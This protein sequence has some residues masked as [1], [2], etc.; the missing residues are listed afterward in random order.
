MLQPGE[1]EKVT[2]AIPLW[3]LASYSENVSCWFLEE[4]QYGLWVGNSLQKAELWG[5][6]QLEGDVILSE[7][8][9]VCGLKERL[10]ELEPT[11]EKV[12]EKEYLWHKKALELPSIVLNQDIFKKEVIL[13]D[14]KEKTE[15]RAGEITDSLSADQLIAFT[16]GDP[17]R[18]QAFLAGQT[19]QT[20][21]GAAAETTSAAAGKPWEVASIVLAD[22]PAGL[23][24]KKE[25]QV[26]DGVIDSGTLMEALEGGFFAD[27]KEMEGTVYYQYCTAVPVGTLLA[28]TWNTELLTRVGEMIGEEM[29]LFE[30]TLWLAPG[31]NI[32]R[33]PLCGRNFEYYSED[34][35]LSGTMAAAIT[36][37]CSPFRDAGLPSNILPAITRKITEW[38]RTVLSQ[39][40]P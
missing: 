32:H 38:A 24:L 17:N 34:P 12:S 23:R 8:V 15:G 7:S 3:L 6:L 18:G 35:L 13:Y 19:R 11:Q 4:G 27:K 28:Q 22:G 2:I 39:K 29:R 25:Y 1:A 33:N 30:V 16:T 37:G 31:M 26:K 40:E 21:P 5:S 9:P 20:V 10:E 14:Y 36:K